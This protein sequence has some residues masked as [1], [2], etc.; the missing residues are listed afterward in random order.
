VGIRAADTV[1]FFPPLEES[2]WQPREA[3]GLRIGGLV[4][5]GR[6]LLRFDPWSER[7]A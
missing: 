7:G 5:A 1:S 6:A 3:P 4:V 2:D